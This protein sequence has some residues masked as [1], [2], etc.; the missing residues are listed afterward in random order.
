MRIF[1]HKIS[2]RIRVACPGLSGD[3]CPDIKICYKWIIQVFNSTFTPPFSVTA[4]VVI[5]A[6]DSSFIRTTLQEH[7]SQARHH[8][9]NPGYKLKSKEFISNEFKKYDLETHEHNFKGENEVSYDLWV[10]IITFPSP[11]YVGAIPVLKITVIKETCNIV[12]EATSEFW[13]GKKD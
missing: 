1:N 3:S 2:A 4:A 7:F 13:F 11:I 5:A 6:G 12:P 8:V 9:S 10:M